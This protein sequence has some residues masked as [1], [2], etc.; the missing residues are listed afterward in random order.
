MA[1]GRLRAGVGGVVLLFSMVTIVVVGAVP[2]LPLLVLY[3][4]WYVAWTSRAGAIFQAWVGLLLRLFWGMRFVV[5]GDDMGRAQPSVVMS[6]HRTRLDW[7]LLWPL[8]SAAGTMDAL[9]IV[10]KAD[11]KKLPIMG[12]SSQQTRYLF[13]SR[14]WEADAAHMTA[15]LGVIADQGRYSVLIFPEGTDLHPRG[16]DASNTFADKH[17]LP[18]Y[19]YVLHPR[20]RGMAHV[21]SVLRADPIA[22]AA[23]VYD[24]TLAYRGAIAQNEVHLL[25]GVSPDEVHSHVEAFRVAD[26]PPDAAGTEAWVAARFARKE[27]VLRHFYTHPHCSLPEAIAAVDAAAPATAVGVDSAAPA[28]VAA[29]AAPAA[30]PDPATAPTT[31]ATS[32]HDVRLLAQLNGCTLMT[33]LN[34]LHL[35][36]WVRYPLAFVAFIAAAA[37]FFHVLMPRV[38]GLDRV[39]VALHGRRAAAAPPRPKA[40]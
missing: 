12:W 39:E 16:R 19:D 22:P 40:D 38:G 20:T 17:G 25:T 33:A 6:N 13:L 29:P 8:F 23:A 27:R 30:S 24:V 28:L 15:M 18:H 14:K 2:A 5:S 37:L 36:L 9:R 35:S 34:V 1:V 10:L 4:P 21:V 31:A 11:I 26:L 32:V 7:A 3:Y